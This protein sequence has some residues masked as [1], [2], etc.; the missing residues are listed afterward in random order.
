M[1]RG[2]FD[3]ALKSLALSSRGF[4][5]LTGLHPTTVSRWGGEIPSIPRWVAP[6]LAAW[7]VL[8]PPHAPTTTQPRCRSVPIKGSE[9]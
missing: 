6:L 9:P 1:T 8:G 7:Q 5:E 2:E 3:T 4:C